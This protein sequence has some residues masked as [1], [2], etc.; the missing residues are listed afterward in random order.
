MRAMVFRLLVV[1]SFIVLSGCANG[2]PI[3]SDARIT[4]KNEAS[5]PVYGFSLQFDNHSTTTVNADGSALAS[6]EEIS[7]DFTK[8]DIRFDQEQGL[9]VSILIEEHEPYELENS[10]S[11]FLTQDAHFI[12]ELTGSTGEDASLRLQSDSE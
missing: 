1:A 10:F 12:F 11:L 5:F 6:G 2:Q 4:I 9:V 3:E 7:F 8:Q